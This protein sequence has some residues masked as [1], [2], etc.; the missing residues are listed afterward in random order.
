MEAKIHE[1]NSTILNESH[2]TLSQLKGLEEERDSPSTLELVSSPRGLARTLT[3]GT[4][5]TRLLA[6][7]NSLVTPVCRVG[8][9]HRVPGV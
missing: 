4:G 1:N 7:P 3:I 5:I 9:C 2:S 8:I 6:N